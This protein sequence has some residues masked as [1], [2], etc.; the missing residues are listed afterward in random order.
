V[1]GHNLATTQKYRNVIANPQAALVV[2][3][4]ASVDPWQ[5][6]AVIV[7]GSAKTITEGGED[8]IRISPD[9]ILSW[10]VDG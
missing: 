3:D 5:P 2:D 7:Q 1:G 10:G 8:L 9:K 6:R 4:L